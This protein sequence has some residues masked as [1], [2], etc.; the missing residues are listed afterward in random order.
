MPVTKD[1]RAQADLLSGLV[2]SDQLALVDATG[3]VRAYFDGLSPKTP[4]QIMLAVQRLLQE[5]SAT[6]DLPSQQL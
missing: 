4:D 2:H 5:R 3:T 6:T 1:H